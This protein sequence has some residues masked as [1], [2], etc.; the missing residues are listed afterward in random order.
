MRLFVNIHHSADLLPHF[1]RHYREQGVSV[2]CVGVFGGEC[3][4]HWSEINAS[5]IGYSYERRTFGA[6][7]EPMYGF[8]DSCVQDEWRKRI[9]KPEEWYAVADLD[10]F[11]VGYDGLPL[12]ELAYEADMHGYCAVTGGL[13]DRITATGELPEQLE[14]DIWKQ[15]PIAIEATKLM[16]KGNSSKQILARGDVPIVS[17]HHVHEERGRWW[18]LVVHHFK[19]RANLRA[20]QEK[21]A[22]DYRA[23]SLGWQDPVNVLDHLHRNGQRLNVEE[24]VRQ[25]A[26]Y[27]SKLGREMVE[28]KRIVEKVQAALTPHSQN[29]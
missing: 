24:L 19:W 16:V 7:G 14:E 8:T 18:R 23:L 17:G 21:R 13:F 25:D 12:G 9:I 5:L 20:V 22:Q 3:N 27:R 15:F 1:L 6:Y 28:N 10:E 26:E 4:P 29:S 2:F 11:A